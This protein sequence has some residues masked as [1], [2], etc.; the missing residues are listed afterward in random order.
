VTFSPFFRTMR[1]GVQISLGFIRIVVAA[2]G[3]VVAGVAAEVGAA[4]ARRKTTNIPKAA[5]VRRTAS[6]RSFAVAR[7]LMPSAAPLVSRDRQ[8]SRDAA[9]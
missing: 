7:S 9:A 2:A 1:V 8:V 3:T 6:L 5:D 4:V